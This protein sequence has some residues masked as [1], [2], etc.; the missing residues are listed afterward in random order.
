MLK[1]I[2]FS[3]FFFYNS[4]EK[5]QADLLIAEHIALS[6]LSSAGICASN[7]TL[8]H[9]DQYQFLVIHHRLDLKN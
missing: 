8:A 1:Q 4:M 7:S 6:V 2:T 3:F 5:D 9:I